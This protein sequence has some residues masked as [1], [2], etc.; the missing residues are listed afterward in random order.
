MD[1]Y[2]FIITRQDGSECWIKDESDARGYAADVGGTVRPVEA[3][4]VEILPPQTMPSDP[5]TSTNQS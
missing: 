1:G 2:G 5:Y 4:P 3:A